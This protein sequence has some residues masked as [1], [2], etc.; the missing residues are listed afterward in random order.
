VPEETLICLKA[1]PK[2]MDTDCATFIDSMPSIIGIV[3]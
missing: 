1:S 3:S 2:T